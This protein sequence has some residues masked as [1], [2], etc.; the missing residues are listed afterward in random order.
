MNRRIHSPS[1]WLQPLTSIHSDR[2]QA[3]VR[4]PNTA[5]SPSRRCRGRTGF[6]SSDSIGN[7]HSGSNSLGRREACTW[8]RVIELLLVVSLGELYLSETTD[9][10]VDDEDIAYYTERHRTCRGRH[11]SPLMQCRHLQRVLHTVSLWT[12]GEA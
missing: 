11:C 3:E 7:Y 2:R 9:S 6:D 4:K 8:W 12:A 10:R 5:Y 1:G